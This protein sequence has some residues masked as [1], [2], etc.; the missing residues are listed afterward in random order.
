MALIQLGA[1]Q[2]SMNLS[3]G[4]LESSGSRN[5]QEKV[6]T[7]PFAGGK[8]AYVVLLLNAS[9]PQKMGQQMA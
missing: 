3:P 4:A 6:H 9:L 1:V 7:K 8:K 5:Q 2:A